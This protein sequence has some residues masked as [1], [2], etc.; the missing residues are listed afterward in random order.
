MG[1]PTGFELHH[2][3]EM[4]EREKIAINGKRV[5]NTSRQA[6]SEKEFLAAKQRYLERYADWLSHKAFCQDCKPKG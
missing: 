3:Y 2:Q 5:P 6:A 1:C 4:A